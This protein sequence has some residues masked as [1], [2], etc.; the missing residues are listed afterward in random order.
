MWGHRK[1]WIKRKET[2]ERMEGC[3]IEIEREK[4][5]VVANSLFSL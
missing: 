3:A 5:R 1:S 2:E 4:E